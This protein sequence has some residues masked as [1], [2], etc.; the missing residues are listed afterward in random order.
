MKP[1]LARLGGDPKRWP[2]RLVLTAIAA[3]KGTF[4]IQLLRTLEERHHKEAQNCILAHLTDPIPGIRRQAARSV[5]FDSAT[6]SIRNAVEKERCTTVLVDMCAAWLRVGGEKGFVEDCLQAHG[7]RSLNTHTG[8]RDVGGALEGGPERLLALLPP[9][10]ATPAVLRQAI[11][12]QPHT[13]QGRSALSSLSKLGLAEDYELLLTLKSSGGRRTEHQRIVALGQHG[14]PR[15]LKELCGLLS[16]MSVDPGR[17]FAHRRTAAIAL[18]QLGLPESQRALI[19]A[20]RMEAVDHE[21]RPGAGLGIQYPVRMDLIW[22]L[23]ET[24]SHRAISALIPLLEDESGSPKGGF[25]LASMD[26]LLKIGEPAVP[27]LSRCAGHSNPRL[28]FNAREVLSAI[29]AAQ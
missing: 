4:R 22:A 14:D 11:R 29:R 20:L 6:D 26:A 16:E 13:E 15:F 9:R 23:G 19:R 3:T 12:N 8:L 24:Q 18:G 7:T 25:Y 2:T 1:F 10:E 27:A 21:G 17:G 5:H 28:A